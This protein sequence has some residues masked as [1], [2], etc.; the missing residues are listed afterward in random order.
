MGEIRCRFAHLGSGMSSGSAANAAT[1]RPRQGVGPAGRGEAE[2]RMMRRQERTE[3]RS[4]A[5][6]P[7]AGDWS[8][9]VTRMA[10]EKFP[11]CPTPD[12]LAT[13]TP[14]SEFRTPHSCLLHIH[15]HQ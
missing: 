9:S 15:A 6:L 4:S 8:I 10:P 14:Q 2:G 13:L 11:L 3:A 7:P 12:N 1:K 5:S